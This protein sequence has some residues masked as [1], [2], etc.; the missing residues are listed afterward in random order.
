[1]QAAEQRSGKGCRGRPKVPRG[2]GAVGRRGS[3]LCINITVV[4]TADVNRRL[5][6]RHNSGSLAGKVH[7]RPDS[8]PT[9]ATPRRRNYKIIVLVTT[10]TLAVVADISLLGT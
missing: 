1:V 2:A 7:S 5:R 3:D 4:S 8:P 10:Y 6:P 9:L